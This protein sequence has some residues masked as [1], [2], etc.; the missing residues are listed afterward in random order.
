MQERSLLSEGKPVVD[1]QNSQ[2]GRSKLCDVLPSDTCTRRSKVIIRD[3]GNE[4]PQPGRINLWLPRRMS[5]CRAVMEVH[6]MAR[7]CSCLKTKNAGNR[8]EGDSY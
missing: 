6:H 7:K 5:A 1:Q 3:Q 4:H 8:A 2:K